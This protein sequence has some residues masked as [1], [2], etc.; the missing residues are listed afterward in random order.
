MPIV[1]DS[2]LE[3]TLR[4][5]SA[6]GVV[7]IRTCTCRLECVTSIDIDN[8]AIAAA[9]ASSSTA[10]ITSPILTAETLDIAPLF[11]ARTFWIVGPTSI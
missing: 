4:L 3:V 8:R 5:Q 10:A 7:A 11:S 9:G 1:V 2:G 6:P